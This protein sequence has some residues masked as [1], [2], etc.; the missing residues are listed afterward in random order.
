M[1]KVCLN[2]P[3]GSIPSHRF[4][5]LSCSQ[6]GDLDADL[7]AEYAQ[8]GDPDLQ[9][10]PESSDKLDAESKHERGRQLKLLGLFLEQVLYVGDQ[11]TR[12]LMWAH[13]MRL[14]TAVNLID[15]KLGTQPAAGHFHTQMKQGSCITKT[16]DAKRSTNDVGSYRNLLDAVDRSNARGKKWSAA[17]DANRRFSLDVLIVW[18]VGFVMQHF[19]MESV[20]DDPAHNQKPESVV[21][22]A[23]EKQ[24]FQDQMQAVAT[25]LFSF[26]HDWTE[27]K[28]EPNHEEAI[29]IL[30]ENKRQKEMYHR[31]PKGCIKTFKFRYGPDI[32][33]HL[34]VCKHEGK[35]TTGPEVK[36]P[37]SVYDYTVRGWN[38]LML[39]FAYEYLIRYNNGPKMI[40]IQAKW[41]VPL[42]YIHSRRSHYTYEG[43]FTGV[44]I[45]FILSVRMAQKMIWDAAVDM[46]R[47]VSVNPAIIALKM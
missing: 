40:E 3:L 13:I 32:A 17:Y 24:W 22:P 41:M 10:E 28:H 19:G 9:P 2:T 26:Q 8:Y 46:I 43:M 29:A 34:K 15:T 18:S 11:T 44:M 23:Q 39:F 21:T 31:C 42:T 30:R 20:T 7:D 12:R 16:I 4:L 25:K 47:K 35:T 27:E 37:D 5:C 36:R 45:E 6:E 33:A 1:V 38:E 14:F